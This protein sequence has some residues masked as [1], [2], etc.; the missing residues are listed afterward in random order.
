METIKQILLSLH[1]GTNDNLNEMITQAFTGSGPTGFGNKRELVLKNTGFW[2]YAAE[3]LI[4]DG[5]R[6]K[7]WIQPISRYMIANKLDLI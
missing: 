5:F 7:D 3:W 4:R 2:A 1:P 6:P